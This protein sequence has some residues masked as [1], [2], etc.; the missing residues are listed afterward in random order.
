MIRVRDN[1]RDRLRDSRTYRLTHP[2][3][4]PVSIITRL[5]LHESYG[6]DRLAVRGDGSQSKPPAFDRRI[7]FDFAG[8]QR[9]RGILI[10]N[11]VAR[12]DHVA[13]RPEIFAQVDRR[14]SGLLELLARLQVSVYIGTAES[15]DRLLGISDHVNSVLASAFNEHVTKDSPLQLVGILELVDQ[16]ESVALAQRR[17]ERFAAN[18]IECI[19]QPHE[20]ILVVERSTLALS[21]VHSRRDSGQKF[22][23]HALLDGR[24]LPA[25]VVPH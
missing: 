20:H 17:R 16:R 3:R 2:A 7:V 1:S 19:R 12:F 9:S 4:K 8:E 5:K 6:R 13:G 22:V 10:E 15:V 11:Q 25:R 18:T 23:D 14:C 24:A 21:R